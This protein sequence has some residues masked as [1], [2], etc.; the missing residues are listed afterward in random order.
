MI[1]F[2]KQALSEDGTPS[3]RRIAFYILLF[4]FLGECLANIAWKLAMQDTLRDQ[5][6][7]AMLTALGT[8]F[9]GNAINAYI[10]WK[11]KQADSN[12]TVGSSTPP[13]PDATK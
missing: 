8:V 10:D 2:L 9:G 13:V 12:A 11:K 4:A 5:L 7:Y 6:Y 1:Q 3:S